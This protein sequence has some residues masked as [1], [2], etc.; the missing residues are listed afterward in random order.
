MVLFLVAAQTAAADGIDAAIGT[1]FPI[2]VGAS[3]AWQHPSRLRL[4]GT[5]GI[6]PEPYVGTINQAMTTFDV[7]S[8]TTAELIDVVLQNAIVLHG[9]VGYQVLPER[10][11]TVSLGYQRIGFAGDTTD[12]S[13]FSDAAIPQEFID[14]AATEF[15]DLEVD[16]TSHMVSGEVGYQWLIKERLVVRGSL[17]FAYTLHA[18]TTVSAT[19]EA[20]TP[21]GEELITLVND[22]ASDYLNYVF[23][24]WVHL[25]MIGVTVGYRFPG[26]RR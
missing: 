5:A 26:G 14:A 21:V 9:Q 10:P 13:L 17:A 16:L 15:G 18:S 19:R 2:L 6:L 24:K 7:Y 1:D 25:P 11:L 23:E 12:I 3:A 8:D 22:A 20:S 4:E